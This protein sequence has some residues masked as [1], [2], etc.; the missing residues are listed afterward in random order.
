MQPP[1]QQ[2]EF[3]MHVMQHMQEVQPH[4]PQ[5]SGNMTFLKFKKMNMAEFAGTTKTSISK[6]VVEMNE[7]NIQGNTLYRR[8][9]GNSCHSYDEKGC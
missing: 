3:T 5:E 7:K 1:Q 2:Q 4:P 6:R 8:R 9:K